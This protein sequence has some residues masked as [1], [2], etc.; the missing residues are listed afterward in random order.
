M[1]LIRWV[2]RTINRKLPA[3]Y[4]I[5]LPEHIRI[6]DAVCARDPDSAARAMRVHL[7]ASR[8][9][10]HARLSDRTASL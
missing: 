7:E 8:Q 2:Q 3:A 4:V 1:D 10:L 6:L 5:A 9:R